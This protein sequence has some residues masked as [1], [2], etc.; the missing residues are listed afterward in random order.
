MLVNSLLKARPQTFLNSLASKGMNQDT[1]IERNQ[2]LICH[3]HVSQINEDEI[4][5]CSCCLFVVGMTLFGFLHLQNV[6]IQLQ[7]TLVPIANPGY[8]APYILE[9][10][11]I[12]KQ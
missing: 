1:I 10:K 7:L 2:P 5:S 12:I 9:Y 8:S 3:H 4:F 11:A 6:R